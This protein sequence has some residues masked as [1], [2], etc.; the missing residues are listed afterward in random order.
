MWSAVA[1][2]LGGA[3]AVSEEVSAAADT[4]RVPLLAAHLALEALVRQQAL[5]ASAVVVVDSR[6]ASADEVGAVAALAATEAAAVS[7]VVAAV[8]DSVA[9]VAEE[10]ASAADAVASDTSPTVSVH[11]TAL[12][13]DLEVHERA[14]LVAAVAVSVAIAEPAAAPLGMA[15]TTDEV[16]VEVVGTTEDLAAQTTSPSAAEIDPSDQSGHATE[17]ETVGMAATSHGSVDTRATA[18]TIR[19]NEGGTE[20]FRWLRCASVRVCQG[21]LPFFRLIISRQWG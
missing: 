4:P 13:L 19:D 18:T 2:S 15:V 5:E 10:E 14:D 9:V 20:L 21:Y 6:A 8:E 1:P 16:A 17:V 7:V 3:P 11:P 12:L